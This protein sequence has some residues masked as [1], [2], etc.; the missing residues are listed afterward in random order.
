M[1]GD[2]ND[3]FVVTAFKELAECPVCFDIYTEPKMLPCIH[4]FCLKCLTKYGEGKKPGDMLACPTCRQEFQVPSAGFPALQGNFF[5]SR[6]KDLYQTAAPRSDQSTALC[7]VCELGNDGETKSVDVENFCVECQ[8]RLC[9]KCCKMHKQFAVS[10]THQIVA[11][12]AGDASS[13]LKEILKTRTSPCEVHQNEKVQLYCVT[14]KKAICM[15]CFAL[16]HR[17]HNYESIE[18]V[19]EKRR[20]LI[21]KDLQNISNKM[22]ALKKQELAV[23]NLNSDLR[24]SVHNAELQINQAAKQLIDLINSHTNKVI[25]DLNEKKQSKMKELALKRQEF[26]SERA[27]MDSF[28]HFASM[29]KENGTYAE[30]ACFGDDT[31]QKARNLMEKES[32][33][34]PPKSDIEIRF[35]TSDAVSKLF[36]GSSNVIGT[37]SS[38]QEGVAPADIPPRSKLLKVEAPAQRKQKISLSLVTRIPGAGCILG[39]TVIQRQIFVCRLRSSN[40]DVFSTA[41]L[42]NMATFTVKGLKDPSDMTSCSINNCLYI[43]GQEDFC[44]FKISTNGKILDQWKMTDKPF[45]ISVDDRGCVTVTFREALCLGVYAADGSRLMN[46]RLPSDMKSPRNAIRTRDDK[47]VVCHGEL[48]EPLHRVCELGP[49]GKIIR[50]YGGAEGSDPTLINVP[51][52][53]IKL[54]EDRYL[55]ADLNN[56]RVHLIEDFKLVQHLLQSNDGIKVPRKLELSDDNLFVAQD[57]GSI[58]VFKVTPQREV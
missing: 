11:I 18:E 28:H 1:A 55:V 56:H 27:M 7:E 31:H 33:V 24:Q 41:T 19:A 29:L 32:V 10:R 57:D 50:W 4:T 12:K 5:V 13:A 54:P 20:N 6:I 35:Q 44:I 8:Q 42:K 25:E 34:L 9:V 58:L 49:D 48:G 16:T 3:S 43:N 36:T 53:M 52:H 17:D 2:S 22:A 40:V 26:E 30:V 15:L 38:N 14:C 23:E 45:R 46:L 37:L 51:V 47:F 21:D 39:I